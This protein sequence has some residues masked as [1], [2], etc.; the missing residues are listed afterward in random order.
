MSRKLHLRVQV[1]SLAGKKKRNF[2]FVVHTFFICMAFF[3]GGGGGGGGGG[4][5]NNRNVKFNLTSP[6]CMKRGPLKIAVI[7]ILSSN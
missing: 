6:A 2:F 3:G 4:E 7:G 5:L 1:L